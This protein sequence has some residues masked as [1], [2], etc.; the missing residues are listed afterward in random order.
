MS[1]P[2]LNSI[3]KDAAIA[4]AKTE[5]WKT[6]TPEEIVQFQLFTQELAMDFGDFH[7]AVEKVLGRPVFTHEFADF[8]SLQ[9]ELLGEK[10]APTFEDIMNMIPEEK[11][12]LIIA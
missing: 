3:G 9:R 4:L 12:M 1:T 10:P 2:T 11:R 7:G 6:K 8:A 5:W